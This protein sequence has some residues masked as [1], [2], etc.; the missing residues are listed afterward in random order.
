MKTLTL[1]AL[2]FCFLV[3]S[4]EAARKR[5]PRLPKPGPVIWKTFYHRCYSSELAHGCRD[6]ESYTFTMLGMGRCTCPMRVH[7]IWEEG[8]IRYEHRFAR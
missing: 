3:P 7:Y 4:A 8:E 2:T 5:T 6:R 1:L